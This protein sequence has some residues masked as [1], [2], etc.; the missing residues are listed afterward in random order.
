[1]PWR[2][3]ACQLAIQHSELE[4]E[5][6]LGVR[7][8]CHICRLELTFDPKTGTLMASSLADDDDHGPPAKET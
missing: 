2:C 8:R 5:P 3:P 1:M 4:L 7:Y 6:R